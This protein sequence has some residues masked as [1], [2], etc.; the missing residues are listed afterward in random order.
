MATV[1]RG[2]MS[3]LLKI[4]LQQNYFQF[5]DQL[6][7]QIQGTAMGTKMAPSYAN[8]FMAELEEM[9]LANYHIKPSLWK[10]Y[11]DDILCFWPNTPLELDKFIEYLNQSHPTIK[12]THESST[13][14]VDF[15]DLTI[16]KGQRH[17][18]SFLLDIKPFLKPTNKFQYLEY[19]SAH[20]KGTF[21]SLTKGVLT[22]PVQTK[23]HTNR[24]QTNS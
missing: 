6:Y 14:S 19:N 2:T 10:R 18:S 7:H 20:P 9:L 4:V 1:P 21:A 16:Y 23:K 3:D 8:I 17:S 5:T 13:T 12:F 11:I 24:F 22:E 15:L